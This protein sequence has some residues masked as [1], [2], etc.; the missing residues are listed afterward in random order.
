MIINIWFFVAMRERRRMNDENKIQASSSISSSWVEGWSPDWKRSDRR[1]LNHLWKELRWRK[2]VKTTCCSP[3]VEVVSEFNLSFC[4]SPTIMSF[5]PSSSSGVRANADQG[6][7]GIRLLCQLCLG[8]WGRLGFCKV[9]Q[10]KPPRLPKNVTFRFEEGAV[11]PKFYFFRDG[12]GLFFPGQVSQ[13]RTIWN[14]CKFPFD[15]SQTCFTMIWLFFWL[16]QHQGISL[17]DGRVSDKVAKE[18]GCII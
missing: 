10:M 8:L 6:A 13:S 5:H 1:G 15:V 18:Q 14:L 12:L 17:E 11:V 16:I 7:F 9:F 2:K 4:K 3:F